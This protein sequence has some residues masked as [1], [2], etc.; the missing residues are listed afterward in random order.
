[1]RKWFLFEHA[2]NAPLRDGKK[3]RGLLAAHLVDEA[4]QL[5]CNTDEVTLV[6][7]AQTPSGFVL[8]CVLC[9]AVSEVAP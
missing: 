8:A 5:V 9:L 1:M 6:S 7:D 2:T 4:Q 3:Q